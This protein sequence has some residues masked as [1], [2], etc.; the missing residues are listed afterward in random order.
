MS[1]SPKSLRPCRTRARP[2]AR[3]R[4]VGFA[5][6]LAVLAIGCGRAR[7]PSEAAGAPAPV[8][9]VA[10]EIRARLTRE[11]IADDSITP[12]LDRFYSARDDRPAWTDEQ[13]LLPRA[14]TLLAVVAGAD[15]DGLEPADYPLTEILRLAAHV[16][17]PDSVARLDVLLSR[18]FLA[19][20][21]D[22]SAGRAPASKVDPL[23][24]ADTHHL[25][26]G[27][28][29]EQ[30]ARTDRVPEILAE[31]RPPQAG[32][33]RLRAALARYREIARRGGW[34][35]IDDG[36]SMEPGL[37]DARAP[38]LRERLRATGDLPSDD[39][40]DGAEFDPELEAALRRFQSRHGLEAVGVIDAAT[41]EALNVPIEDR[42]R[43]LE[44]NLERWR[45]LPRDL[46]DRYLLV[47]AAARRLEVVD[48]GRVVLTLRILV[49]RPDWPT[50]ILS[51]LVTGVTLRPSW[52]VPREIVLRE[53]LP[54]VERTPGYLAREGIHV[55]ALQDDGWA[56][57]HPDSLNAVDVRDRVSS[58]RFVQEPGPLNP[59]GGLRLYAPNR[60]SVY[61]HDTPARHLFEESKGSVTHGCV[62]VDRIETLA[63]YL[64]RGDPRWTE[65]SI[66]AA[67]EGSPDRTIGLAQ[68]IAAHLVY[69][70][71]T[72]REDGTV[73]F[74]PDV[75]DWNRRLQAA[76]TRGAGPF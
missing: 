73:E 28:A 76:L 53:V 7:P 15:T 64:L 67:M 66:R 41:L 63:A 62:R 3:R 42:I 38:L 6:G 33:E 10:E 72:A 5:L 45:W 30:A 25:D 74:R 48:S 36:D 21:T 44:L 19:Y 71:A 31:L 9:S 55:W 37:G 22:L 34:P 13:R 43:E 1:T 14:M 39:G 59:L 58:Y 75:Y 17:E 2:E 26:V 8:P 65:A 40:T 49:G 54:I 23:W 57:V 50:P 27:Q 61:L 51:T 56:E 35:R 24:L 46:G 12:L 11:A 47:N 29:L 52:T 60:F 68:P 4:F 32:Y 70:T 18:T 20:A 16:H 69:F